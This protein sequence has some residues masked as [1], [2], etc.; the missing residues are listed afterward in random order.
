LG[1]VLHEFNGEINVSVLTQ[2][3]HLSCDIGNLE[4]TEVLLHHGAD[5]NAR[6]TYVG[7][8]L[9]WAKTTDIAEC[10]ITNGAK[11]GLRDNFD[12]TKLM[13]AVNHDWNGNIDCERMVKL[14]IDAGSDVNAYCNDFEET[15]LDTALKCQNYEAVEILISNGAYIKLD[16]NGHSLVIDKIEDE[17]IRNSLYEAYC[18]KAHYNLLK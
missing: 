16:D 13:W 4:A 5:L 8:S 2:Y 18:N 14:Q 12:R 1:R 9:A 17:E 11:V 10:L 7:H 6:D 15:V 3:L